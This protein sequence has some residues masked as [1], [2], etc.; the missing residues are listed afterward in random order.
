MKES[1]VRALWPASAIYH[2][3][4]INYTVHKVPTLLLGDGICWYVGDWWIG[5]QASDSALDT[6][7]RGL[8]DLASVPYIVLQ[9]LE[10]SRI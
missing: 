1:Q 2:V 8:T 4:A 6:Y 7:R 9:S 5:L 3:L 10:M